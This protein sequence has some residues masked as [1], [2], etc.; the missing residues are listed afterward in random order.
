[1]IIIIINEG[2]NLGYRIETWQMKCDDDDNDDDDDDD[3]GDDD[4]DIDSNNYQACPDC[5]KQL[6]SNFWA[7][8]ASNNL[9]SS[10]FRLS[11]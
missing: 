10:N 1:M 4:N 3:D 11:M 8:R 9:N 6:L 5:A 2:V 7:F